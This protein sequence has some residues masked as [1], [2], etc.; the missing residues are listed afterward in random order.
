MESRLDFV[1]EAYPGVID[2]G[3]VEV[4]ESE[5]TGIRAYARE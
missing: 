5:I 2:P 3:A 1:N 4:P